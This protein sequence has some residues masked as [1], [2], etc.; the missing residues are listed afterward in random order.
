[1][2]VVRRMLS[3]S[4]LGCFF[5]SNRFS[6]AGGQL[7]CT[8]T[9][10]SS[11]NVS[12][13]LVFDEW[14]RFQSD[15]IRQVDTG[16]GFSIQG[17]SFLGVATRV[18][19]TSL[20][21]LVCPSTWVSCRGSSLRTTTEVGT[22]LL[23]HAGWNPTSSPG[24]VSIPRTRGGMQRN[25]QNTGGTR[26]AVPLA[27]MNPP[28]LGVQEGSNTPIPDTHGWYKPNHPSISRCRWNP[29]GH[30]RRKVGQLHHGRGRGRSHTDAPTWKKPRG[31]M[32]LHPLDRA[33]P[34]QHGRLHAPT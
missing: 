15:L 3:A 20:L 2:S 28:S 17:R 23:D 16:R 29:W 13:A 12:S 32:T 1:M 6:C 8:R 21:G 7:R 11:R 22:P 24:C 27:S 31:C 25:P 33:R 26:D 5:L 30:R 4:I 34:P 14:M 18:P 19:S 10:S 9:S